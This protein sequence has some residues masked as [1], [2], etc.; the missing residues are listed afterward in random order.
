MVAVILG[1]VKGHSASNGGF[2]IIAQLTADLRDLKSDRMVPW[3]MRR[4]LVGFAFLRLFFAATFF[5]PAVF[6][7]VVSFPRWF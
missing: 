3:L 2:R 5:L 6:F 4:L 7:A 1:T